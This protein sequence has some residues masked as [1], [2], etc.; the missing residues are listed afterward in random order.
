M[1]LD[2]YTYCTEAEIVRR[3]GAEA[4]VNWCDHDLDQIAD[5]GVLDDAINQAT[6][7]INGFACKWYAPSALGASR[8]INRWCVTLAAYFA[9]TSRGNPAPDQL[10]RE[11]DRIMGLLERIANMTY[12]LEGIAWRAD[13]SPSF[14]NLHVDR[15][16]VRQKIRVDR[17][18]SS[19][20][21]SALKQNLSVDAPAMFP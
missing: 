18:D 8:V 2:T 1:T 3:Y 7:E 9:S 20:S 6:A 13:L 10:Q 12:Q 19:D 17:G 5:T 14:S 21:P 16:F 11:F 4:I 15:R